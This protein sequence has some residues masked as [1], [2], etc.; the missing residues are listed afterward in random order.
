MTDITQALL[1]KGADVHLKSDDGKTALLWAA[2]K[3]H[4]AVVQAL[5]A[6]KAKVQVKDK[7]GNTAL[8]LASSAG[9]TEIARLLREAGAQE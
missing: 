3:R 7:A 1:A 8:M 2:Y 9:H 5:L 4:P 6:K